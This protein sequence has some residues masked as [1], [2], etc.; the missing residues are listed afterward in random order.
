MPLQIY[1]NWDFWFENIPSGN[2]ASKL[3]AVRKKYQRT[4]FKTRKND[5]FLTTITPAWHFLSQALKQFYDIFT[6]FY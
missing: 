4:V 1:P 3:L 5:F 6:S 2:P